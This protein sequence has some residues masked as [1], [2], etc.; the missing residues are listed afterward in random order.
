MSLGLSNGRFPFGLAFAQSFAHGKGSR[1]WI[2]VTDVCDVQV[3]WE[4][5]LD[6]AASWQRKRRLQSWSPMPISADAK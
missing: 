3:V 1:S 4:E 5:E 2:L 6:M